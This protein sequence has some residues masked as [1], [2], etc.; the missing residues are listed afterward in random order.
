[1]ISTVLAA[2]ETVLYDKTSN[3][4]KF[5]LDFYSF[6]ILKVCSLVSP[7]KE[8]FLIIREREFVEL[9]G[10]YYSIAGLMPPHFLPILRKSFF[11]DQII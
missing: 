6:E 11:I 2:T 9:T 4:E 5:L 3:L 7:N 1:M 8:E 10:F